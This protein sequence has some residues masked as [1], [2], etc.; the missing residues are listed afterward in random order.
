MFV[1]V[2]LLCNGVKFVYKIVVLC[3]RLSLLSYFVSFVLCFFFLFFILLR[4]RKKFRIFYRIWL[5]KFLSIVVCISYIL[6]FGLGWWLLCG[7]FLL[8][9]IVK[10]SVVKFWMIK[11]LI[12]IFWIVGGVLCLM[13]GSLL[14]WWMSFFVLWMGWKIGWKCF[15]WCIIRGLN[16]KKLFR[17]LI[18]FLVWLK[19]GFFLYVRS[20][21]K[22]WKGCIIF[23]IWMNYWI[24]MVV[25]RLLLLKFLLIGN[26]NGFV[27]YWVKN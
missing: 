15:F 12:I 18:F 5:I 22:G 21:R 7:I 2:L 13:V 17:S 11:F 10:R 8:I 27:I 19:V 24:K 3:Y 26:L 16:M 20:C 6:I 25:V 9:I 1:I 23:K 4:M 14:W